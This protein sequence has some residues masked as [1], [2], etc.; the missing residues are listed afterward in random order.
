MQATELD[1][2]QEYTLLRIDADIDGFDPAN[3]DPDDDVPEKEAIYLLKMTCP[4]TGFIHPLLV[5]PEMQSARGAIRWV[6]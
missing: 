6:N 4:S 1:C 3:F 2:W 5:P